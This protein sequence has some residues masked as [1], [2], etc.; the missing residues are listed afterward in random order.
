MLTEKSKNE[1]I[2][3]FLKEMFETDESGISISDIQSKFHLHALRR[4]TSLTRNV[5]I[6]SSGFISILVII[7][8]LYV[9]KKNLNCQKFR[10]IVVT[11]PLANN[12]GDQISSTITL[13]SIIP[14]D[15]TLK[16]AENLKQP[17]SRIYRSDK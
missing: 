1:E 9:C 13:S 3:P 16:S 2:K 14:E 8:L 7:I 12:Q 10:P 5:F 4:K 15:E 11:Q 6:T 17:V